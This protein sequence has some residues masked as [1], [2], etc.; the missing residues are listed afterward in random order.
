MGGVDSAMN[1]TSHPPDPPVDGGAC[2]QRNPGNSPGS[3]PPLRPPCQ[4]QVQLR[5]QARRSC[6]SSPQASSVMRRQMERGLNSC[7]LALTCGHI[8]RENENIE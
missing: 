2:P 3:S 4:F 6:G 8:S 1:V 7:P 5:G